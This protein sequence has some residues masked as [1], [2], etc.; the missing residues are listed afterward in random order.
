MTRH[1]SVCC[2]HMAASDR[3]GPHHVSGLLFSTLA[4]L[5]GLV[6]CPFC[7]RTDLGEGWATEPQ[8]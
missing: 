3:V 2:A 8:G 4:L 1:L 5:M 7:W 6:P